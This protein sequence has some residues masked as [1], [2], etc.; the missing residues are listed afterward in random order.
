MNLHRKKIMTKEE[1]INIICELCD[2]R[3][4]EAFHIKADVARHMISESIEEYIHDLI[5]D[6]SLEEINGE[7]IF[8]NLIDYYRLPDTHKYL[9]SKD[10]D[11]MDETERSIHY[12]ALP[13]AKL[14]LK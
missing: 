8:H 9:F 7:R 11:D 2:K 4:S 6:I 14:K 3:A 10:Y 12:K 5:H 13:P 1:L